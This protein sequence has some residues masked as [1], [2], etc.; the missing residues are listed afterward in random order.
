[1]KGYKD[2]R[3]E[4]ANS[5]KSYIPKEKWNASDIDKYTIDSVWDSGTV[6]LN[7]PEITKNRIGYAGSIDDYVIGRT[8]PTMMSRPNYPVIPTFGKNQ[9]AFSSTRFLIHSPMNIIRLEKITNKIYPI[10]YITI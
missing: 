2:P 9:K 7:K 4:T 1:M 8:F 3:T 5:P 6:R 10:T